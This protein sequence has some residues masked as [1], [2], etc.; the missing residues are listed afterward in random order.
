M[1][2]D[3]VNKECLC[4]KNFRG[5]IEYSEED[6]C[7]FGKILNIDDLCLYEGNDIK[8]LQK[9]FEST[10]EDY[11]EICKEYNKNIKLK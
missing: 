3:N 5:S 2:G 6:K 10:V 9:S 8:E 7:Y 11:I 1:C 4:Y